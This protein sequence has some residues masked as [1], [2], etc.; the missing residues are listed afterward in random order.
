MQNENAKTSVGVTFALMST[1]LWGSYPL[2]YTPLKG[3]DSV[4]VLAVRVI[5]SLFFVL[6]LIALARNASYADVKLLLQDKRARWVLGSS[7]AVSGIWWLTYIIGVTNDMV[8]EA[9]LG[10]F[11]SPIFSVL[12]GFLI[13]KERPNSIQWIAIALTA[14]AILNLTQGYGKTP[15]VALI[16]GLCFSLY[17]A[18]RKGVAIKPL[19]GLTVECIL[20]LPF[21]VVYFVYLGMSAG[22]SFGADTSLI[23]WAVLSVVGLISVLPLWWYTVAAQ[24]LEMITLAFFQLIPPTC[25]FVFAV[26]LFHEPFTIHHQI[27]FILV[28]AAS[29]IY[30]LDQARIFGKKPD[31]A[32]EL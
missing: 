13:F 4:D 11:I 7:A 29:V 20:L 6:I 15:W 24:N 30:L 1:L 18:I 5:G 31:M 9:S 21:A 3:I 2:W 32:G 19:P 8:L 10:Y 12:F 28:L 14:A 25:N 22:P 17:A 23:Q 27:S 26:F 16:I